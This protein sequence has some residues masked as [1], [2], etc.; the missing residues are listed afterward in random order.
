MN[1][2]AFIGRRLLALVGLLWILSFVVFALLSL[3]PG[4]PE[5]ALLGTRPASPETLANIRKL[6]NLD[7][8]LLEQYWIWLTNALHLDFGVSIQN[9]QPVTD[10]IQQRVT[11]SLKL[12]GLAFLL[13]IVL[14]LALGVVAALKERSAVDR[15]VV[16]G[17]IMGVSAP[18]FVTGIILL[19]L[20]G[21]QLTWFPIG[22]TGEGLRSYVLPAVALAVGMLALIT[23]IARASLLR[24]LRRDHVRFARARG[25][26]RWHVLMTHVVRNGMIPVVTS[27]GL[28]LALMFGGTLLVETVFSL[29]GLGSLLV[30]ATLAH[31]YPVVQG[32]VLLIAVVIVVVNLLVDLLYPVLD[33]RVRF[34]REAA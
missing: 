9:Q 8:P 31:D 24:E 21:V 12:V 19:Y 13:A 23:R 6:Y 15:I 16:G 25:L 7:K 2:A 22:G 34:G 29:P 11:V 28:V 3:A 27:A 18:A 1:V 20:F 4:S 32:L 5:R 33:P 14:G 17:T 10:L 26:G 30:S